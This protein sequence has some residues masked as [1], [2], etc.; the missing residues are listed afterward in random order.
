MTPTT[1]RADLLPHCTAN[2]E[3]VVLST[4]NRA[5]NA[6]EPYPGAAALRFPE[7]LPRGRVY[8]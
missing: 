1:N 4:R 2:G 7:G 3:N 6:S 5:D 8:P